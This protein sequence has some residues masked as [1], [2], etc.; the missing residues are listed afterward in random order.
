MPLT[1]SGNNGLMNA[2]DFA[3]AITIFEMGSTSL[4]VYFYLLFYFF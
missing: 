2:F 3:Q 1:S 4:L